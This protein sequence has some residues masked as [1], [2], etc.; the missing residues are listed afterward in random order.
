MENFNRSINDK[1][2]YKMIPFSGISYDIG[3]INGV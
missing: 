2:V 3:L 1:K